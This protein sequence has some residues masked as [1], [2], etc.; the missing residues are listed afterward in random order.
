[1]E[2]SNASAGE[3]DSL[4]K[5]DGL[6]SPFNM[7]LKVPGSARGN[8]C[9]TTSVEHGELETPVGELRAFT[10]LSVTVDGRRRICVF[11]HSPSSVSKK[12]VVLYFSAIYQTREF[13]VLGPK[14]T[15]L[16]LKTTVYCFDNAKKR[17]EINHLQTK[18][19]VTSEGSA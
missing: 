14:S 5:Q 18:K 13:H 8:G 9:Q 16:I 2:L 3:I 10:S 12:F 17:I 11:V 7:A 4:L 6:S 15:G 19:I 1:M